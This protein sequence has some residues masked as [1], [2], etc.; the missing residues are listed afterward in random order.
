MKIDNSAIISAL[1]AAYAAHCAAKT[2]IL[3]YEIGG[4]VYAAEI[5]VEIVLTEF[6]GVSMTS[7]E[8]PCK[9][10]RVKPLTKKSAILFNSFSPVLVC[11][12][13]E[14]TARAQEDFGGNRGQAFESIMCEYYHGTAAAANTPFWISGDFRANGVEYQVKYCNA[15]IVHE[16]HLTALQALK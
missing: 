14:L 3:G 15:T 7:D 10:M 2:V 13:N 9:R 8:T 1:C 6:A 11:S 4:G 5:P 12:F 16:K